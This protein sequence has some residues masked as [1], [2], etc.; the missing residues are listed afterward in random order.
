MTDSMTI[1][2]EN[3]SRPVTCWLRDGGQ[4][5][6]EVRGMDWSRTAL[7]PIESWPQS[8]RT[9]ASM[10]LASNY[11]ASL[12]WGKG[13][14]QVYNDGYRQICGKKHREAIGSNFRESW[15]SAWPVIGAAFE[16]ALS[17]T[18]S[19]PELQRIFMHRNGFLEE[20]FFSYS[21]TP[22]HG[23]SGSVEGVFHPVTEM[24]AQV[25]SERRAHTLRDVMVM[26][27]RAHS[28]RQAMEL[29]VGVLA[30]HALDI[31]FAV[32]YILDG[33]HRKAV[34]VQS[35]GPV[36]PALFRAQVVL[37]HNPDAAQGSDNVEDS[38]L[39]SLIEEVRSKR[40]HVVVDDLEGRFGLIPGGEPYPEA[41]RHAVA[42]PV[43][44]Q[45]DLSHP[46]LVEPVAVLIA[47]TSARLPLNEAYLAFLDVLSTLMISSAED[48][49]A[50]RREYLSEERSGSHFLQEGDF[51]E[52]S[53]ASYSLYGLEARENQDWISREVKV[54]EE[55]LNSATDLPVT[56]RRDALAVQAHSAISAEPVKQDTLMRQRNVELEARVR[57]RTA[58]LALVARR[59]DREILERKLSQE[60]VQWL[61]TFPE[62]N[63]DPVVE[64]DVSGSGRVIYANPTAR[65]IPGLDAEGVN[66]GLLDGLV[67]IAQRT[68]LRGVEGPDF[69]EVEAGGRCYS[70]R[71]IY[72]RE[73]RRIR[74]YS[75]DITKR[76]E[77][78]T[79]LRASEAS[80]RELNALLE[81][82]VMER[83][84]E[85]EAANLELEA[86]SYTVS[87]DLRTPLRAINGYVRAV[88]E[89]YEDLLPSDGRRFLGIVTRGAHRMG[90]LI[91]DL[92]R[93]SRFSR[94][95]LNFQTVNMSRTVNDTL[96]E[97]EAVKRNRS[98]EIHV[99]EDMPNCLGDPTL[100]RQVW[101]NLI[102]NSL[103][104]ARNKEH[105]T[106]HIGSY[107][108]TDF[109]DDL[110]LWARASVE[111]RKM[112]KCDKPLAGYSAESERRDFSG[113]SSSINALGPETCVYYI[114]DNGTGFDMRYVDA[115]FGVF[116]RLHRDKEYE[117]TGVGLAIARRVIQRHHGQIW[118]YGLPLCGA[119]FS[120]VVSYKEAKLTC[121]PP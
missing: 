116:Q 36:P 23:E 113:A 17:G 25:L 3:D 11:P 43:A 74:T 38:A 41:P 57:Q 63:P 7:G 20:T 78:E 101:A 93:F 50:N 59:L 80:Y 64:L 56:G 105:A 26:S 62:C 99:Q 118:A 85:L 12:I 8:L 15:V 77:A 51:R 5:G 79:A 81:Q 31:P 94:Q 106:I 66:H 89:D 108:G 72:I 87:H 4:M 55:L 114:V 69:R 29:A 107:R 117:G 14:V 46:S 40:H 58:A 45:P 67:N 52:G 47:G 76:R 16:R 115:L 75:R 88:I 60:R 70:Q 111:A 13:L 104:Y 1:T 86:F 19:G 96:E 34:R 121:D 103:K 2:P 61:A 6:D 33:E 120:F 27:T 71:L 109:P 37:G 100:L 73:T 53:A 65:R 48:L 24:T 83:T 30:Q 112:A 98:V 84:R 82:R 97:M 119:V 22:V 95:E 68:W 10:C 102:S 32:I 110:P 18:A 42:L 44:L 21:F 35:Q 39:A 49:H 28:S 9:M 90:E 91:D 92:L 54:F